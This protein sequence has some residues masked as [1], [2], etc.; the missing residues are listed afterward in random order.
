MRLLTSAKKR[1]SFNAKAGKAEGG[2]VV[3]GLL[4]KLQIRCEQVYPLRNRKD[5]PTLIAHLLSRLQAPQSLVQKFLSLSRICHLHSHLALLG[6]ALGRSAKQKLDEED[7]SQD[8][9]EG[10]GVEGVLRDALQQLL[11]K[12]PAIGGGGDLASAFVSLVEA[13]VNQASH[14]DDSLGESDTAEVVLAAVEVLLSEV[15]GVVQ[16]DVMLE[17]EGMIKRVGLSLSAR[18]NVLGIVS[19]YFADIARKGQVV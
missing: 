11:A 15:P 4:M 14:F 8:G 19:D 16:S 2:G 10:A 1:S 13:M 9:V 12:Y 6:E 3:E 18:D 17:L 7:L 5:N